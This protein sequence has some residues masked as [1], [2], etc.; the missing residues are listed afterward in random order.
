VGKRV[1]EHGGGL[2][3]SAPR[4]TPGIGPGI[5][6]FGPVPSRRLGR[7]LGINHV[8][9]KTC[10]YSC[11][12]CQLGRT[13]RLVISR[14]AFYA[15]DEVLADVRLKLD[16]ARSSGQA[17]DYLTFVPDGEPTLDLNLGPLIERLRPLGIPTAVISNGALLWR[18]D[19]REALGRAD[20][21]S[22]SVDAV[23]EDVW[24]R[25]NRPHRRL[26]LDDV[27]GGM[28]AFARGY[29]GC[30]ATHT[31]LVADVNDRPGHLA[32]LAAFL[33]ELD[34]AVAY[35]AVPTRPP[36]EPWVVPPG[37]ETVRR[38]AGQLL[39]RLKSVQLLTEY[40]GDE[41]VSTGSLVDDLL[42]TA[43][44]HPMRE[45]AVRTL[46]LAAGAEMSVVHALVEAGRLRTTR[47]S[48]HVYYSAGTSA[49]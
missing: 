46:V 24:R 27:L 31:M 5:F 10:T 13:S 19:V 44:V 42:A 38:A 47:F 21:V 36:A 35:L 33:A 25:A 28:L 43:A 34:P 49:R 30:L 41:F 40:E 4:D 14:R 2:K 23:A 12:Y 26:D 32:E 45:D 3:P 18:E 16:A 9:P 22:L 17:V 11:V 48:G 37:A 39:E 6:A 29:R 15:Q 7:S 20:W 8:P 1:G